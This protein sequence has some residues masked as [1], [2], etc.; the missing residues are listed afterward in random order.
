V[1]REHG[2]T[3]QN[4]IFVIRLLEFELLRAKYEEIMGTVKLTDTPPLPE[5]KKKE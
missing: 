5:I 1:I 4:A 3:I 2:A